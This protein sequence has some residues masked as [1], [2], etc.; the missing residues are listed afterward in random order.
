MFEQ[1]C[2]TIL[3]CALSK[4][5]SKDSGKMYRFNKEWAL[6]SGLVTEELANA[7]WDKSSELL[8]LANAV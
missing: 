5:T 6:D 8:G 3:H 7:L 1:G 4:I 2:E